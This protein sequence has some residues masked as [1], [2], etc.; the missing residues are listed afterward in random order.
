MDDLIKEFKQVRLS[1]IEA[2]ENFP[3]EKREN[4]LFGDWSLK[5]LL[6]HLSG[7]AAY[8][9]S[10]LQDFKKGIEPNCPTDIEDFNTRSVYIRKR[11]AWDRVY[12]EFVEKSSRLTDHYKNLPTSKINKNIWSNQ[13]CTPRDFIKIE[14]N[15]YRQTHLPQIHKVLQGLGIRI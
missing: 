7:W 6:S 12:G 3:H 13:I 15:H 10:V 11:W 8:Q 1:L 14:I 9:T 4:P 5:D 2:V